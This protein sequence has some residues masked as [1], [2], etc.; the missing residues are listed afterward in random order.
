MIVQFSQYVGTK[1]RK[2]NIINQCVMFNRTS[3]LADFSY[4]ICDRMLMYLP[5]CEIFPPPGNKFE[6]RVV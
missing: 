6:G 3:L 5:D 1:R 2:L 4:I